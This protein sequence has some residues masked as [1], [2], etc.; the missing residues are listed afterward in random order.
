MDGNEEK[1]REKNGK[2][3]MNNNEHENKT[4]IVAL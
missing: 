3:H 2:P 4:L 1:K